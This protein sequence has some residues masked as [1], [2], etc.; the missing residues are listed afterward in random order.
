MASSIVAVKKQLRKK[1]RDILK[2]LP[3]ASLASQ[4]TCS[5]YAFSRI[6]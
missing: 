4:S 3:E 1:I 5:T 2:D 6:C